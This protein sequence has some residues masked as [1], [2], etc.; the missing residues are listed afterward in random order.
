MEESLNQGAV[1]TAC[2]GMKGKK[3]GKRGEIGKN[4][5]EKRPN[6]S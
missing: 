1:E 6:E 5:D 4:W 3:G 2:K